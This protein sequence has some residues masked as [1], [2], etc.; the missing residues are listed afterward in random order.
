MKKTLTTIIALALTIPLFLFAVTADSFYYA[1]DQNVAFQKSYK[2]SKPF[3]ITPPGM[4]YQDINGKELTDGAKNDGDLYSTVWHGFDYRLEE[5]MFATIDLGAVTDGLIKF[6]MEFVGATTS[7][8][9]PPSSVEFFTSNDNVNFTSVG[10]AIV[11]KQTASFYE[12][13][14]KLKAPISARYIKAAIGKGGNG[15][16][17][18]FCSEFEVFNSK[19]VNGEEPTQ[20]SQETE[21][22]GKIDAVVEEY[23][24]IKFAKNS[25]FSAKDGYLLGVCA[26]DTISDLLRD[27]NTVA[28]ITV[29]DGK[30]NIVTQGNLGTGY[31]ITR[32]F[33]GKQVCSYTVVISGDVD[34]NGKVNAL[35]YLACRLHIIGVK[36]LVGPYLAAMDSDDNKEY[37]PMDYLRIRT[38]IIGT[39][40][41]YVK[42]QKKV[43][44]KDM[45]FTKTSGSEYRMDCI[46]DNGKP[47]YLT[48]NEK[49]WSTWNLGSWHIGDVTITD[50]A[51]DWEYVYRA[52]YTPSSKIEFSGGNHGNEKLVNLKFFD[53]STG[54]ELNPA[55][56][57]KIKIKNLKV[58]ETTKLYVADINRP[59]C[60]VIRTYTVVGQKI[61]LDVAYKFI[62]DCYFNLSY[63]CMFP[64]PKT[65]GLY[66]Q[67]RNDDGTYET[68]KTSKVGSP[69]YDGPMYKGHAASSCLIYGY[70]QTEYSFLVEV[71]TKKD[72]LEDFNSN[73]KTAYWDMNATTNK[74][75][76][77]KFD[78]NVRTHITKGTEWNTSCAWSLLINGK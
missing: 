51:T 60:D 14:V 39:Y 25:M 50:N 19:K 36:K 73:F 55:I 3:T 20:P 31:T 23:P 77:G 76:F 59:Y 53:G 67:F 4:A 11:N 2:A 42:F 8:I 26:G 16:V 6:S 58:V 29:K 43:A 61:T 21:V 32:N 18:V 30:G 38:H 37:Q 12:Y 64:I 15:A 54:N 40:D 56:G 22:V 47:L 52:A 75:Y 74:L 24:D 46:A 72:S 5:P 41:L 71:F 33:N 13:Y 68:I 62:E 35:D 66:I 49:P 48:F 34:G 45:T 28:G 7:G 65:L 10:K 63:T 1:P 44:E 17:F 27:I 69:S 9:A 78:E 57:Q 70:E